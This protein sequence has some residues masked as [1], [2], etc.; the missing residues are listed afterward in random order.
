MILP[1]CERDLRSQ[2]IT[3][4]TLIDQIG[5]LS[6]LSRTIQVCQKLAHSAQYFLSDIQ[7]VVAEWGLLFRFPRNSFIRSAS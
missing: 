6:N 2:E 1:L 7:L 4:K 5:G 3:R